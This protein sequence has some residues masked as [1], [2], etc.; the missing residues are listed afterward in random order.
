VYLGGTKVGE[1]KGWGG[2]ISQAAVNAR[3][4][5]IGQPP[6]APIVPVALVGLTEKATKSGPR[7]V[8][9]WGDM[10]KFSKAEQKE[11]SNF[12]NFWGK[13][14]IDPYRKQ[15]GISKVAG[16]ILQ[17]A[18]AVVPV[19]GYMNA[20]ATA[21][22]YGL[23]A[24]AAKDFEKQAEAVMT[25]AYELLAKQE[26]E[27]ASADFAAQLSALQALRPTA[28]AAPVGV[29][30]AKPEAAARSGWKIEEIAVA[31]I[32][33]FVLLLGVIRK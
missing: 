7:Y 20:V 1:W 9:A 23:Q 24:G 15:S 2:P 29:A 30:S 14:A 8:D 4:S 27:K 22:N 3:W 6:P 11:V 13:V 17:V 16:G 5:E 21:G 19:F 10:V 25:P 18:S 32:A 31:G 28:N 33:G 26:Q 12:R